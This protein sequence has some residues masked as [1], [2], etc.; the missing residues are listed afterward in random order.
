MRNLSILK[1]K[2][3]TLMLRELCES[4]TITDQWRSVDTET[5]K[6]MVENVYFVGCLDLNV[7]SSIGRGQW[8]NGY[9]VWQNDAKNGTDFTFLQITKV[10]SSWHTHHLPQRSYGEQSLTRCREYVNFEQ[11]SRNR[12]ASVWPMVYICQGSL[13][14]SPPINHNRVII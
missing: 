14:I 10:C 9:Q 8:L 11:V 12:F 7:R 1:T 13:D 4:I 6:V 2:K 5:D 3:M